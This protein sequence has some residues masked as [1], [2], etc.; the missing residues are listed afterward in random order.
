MRTKRMTWWIECIAGRS[1]QDVRQAA[2]LSDSPGAA[3]C[4]SPIS[5]QLVGH[6]AGRL[7]LGVAKRHY[8]SALPYTVE[9][10]RQA[11]YATKMLEGRFKTSHKSESN[12]S[13]RICLQWHIRHLIMTW[14]LR[15][16]PEKTDEQPQ[17]FLHQAC[18]FDL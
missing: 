18:F 15:A 8:L 12:H 2:S 16:L 4:K 1:P 17:I 6:R 14:I 13:S 10:M 11:Q 9:L 5:W 3:L 7:F